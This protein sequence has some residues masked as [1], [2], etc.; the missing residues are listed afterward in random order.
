MKRTRNQMGDVG[1]KV[2]ELYERGYSIESIAR[3]LYGKAG[4]KERNRV[5]VVIA[6]LKKR[7]LIT[8]NEKTQEKKNFINSYFKEQLDARFEELE[9]RLNW[10]IEHKAIT[11][12]KGRGFENWRELEEE[13]LAIYTEARG[14]AARALEEG[15]LKRA[16]AFLE[17]ALR[18]LG[19]IRLAKKEA[20]LDE[21]RQMAEELKKLS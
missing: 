5:R 15:D 20:D 17:L 12:R 6:R 2:K 1:K 14:V 11:L 21:L 13:L 19:E 4:E 8:V 10:L 3:K 7:G 16:R 9:K 18:A